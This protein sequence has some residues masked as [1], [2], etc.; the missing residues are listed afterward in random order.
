LELVVERL[1]GEE[2]VALKLE[3][4]QFKVILLNLLHFPSNKFNL[5]EVHVEI[6]L[7]IRITL[8]PQLQQDVNYTRLKLLQTIEFTSLDIFKI[9]YKVFFLVFHLKVGVL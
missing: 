5:V 3:N 6:H 2:A 4:N 9:V 7:E 8:C 1:R